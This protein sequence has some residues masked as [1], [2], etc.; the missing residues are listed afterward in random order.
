M[1]LACEE[2][3][4]RLNRGGIPLK[5]IK[6]TDR[7]KKRASSLLGIVIESLNCMIINY[8]LISAVLSLQANMLSILFMASMFWLFDKYYSTV[9]ELV[10]N[11]WIAF[12]IVFAMIILECVVVYFTGYLKGTITKW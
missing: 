6:E 4:N 1:G 7:A 2:N 9:Q 11:K 12:G 3:Q 10:K 5:E 8:V